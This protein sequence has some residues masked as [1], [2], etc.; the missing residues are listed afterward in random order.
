MIFPEEIWKYIL[1]HLDKDNL[2]RCLL[3]SNEFRELIIKT[4]ELMRKLPVIFFNESWKTKLSFIEQYGVF[5]RSIKFDDCGFK[6]IKDVRNILIQTPNVETLIFYNCYIL[7]AQEIH[8]EERG[9]NAILGN[10][11]GFD[12]F[13]VNNENNNNEEENH[14][15]VS[16]EIDS[17]RN[18]S[19][20]EEEDPLDLLK[21]T[22]LHLDSCN[23][24][25]KVVQNLRTCTT[26]KTFKITFY[27]QSPVNYF[28]NFICQ[29]DSLEELHCVGWSDMV[30]KSLFKNNISSDRIKFKLKK[31]C[32]ECELGYHENFS[33]F[34]RSQAGN[35]KELDLT[36]YNINF[37]YYRLIFNSFKNLTSLTLPTDWFLTDDRV[38]DIK[39]CKIPSLKELELIGAND[40]VASFKTVVEIFPNIE[41]LRA[42]NLMYFSL[43]DILENFSNL[44]HLKAENFR[45]ETMLFVNLPSLKIVEISYLFPMAMSFLWEN[46]AQSCPNIEKLIIKDIGHFK[47]NASIKKEIGLIIKN[48]VNFKELKYC[49]IICSLQ[50]PMVN[51]DED[52]Q[53]AHQFYEHPFYK[54]IIENFSDD[55]KVIKVSQYFAQHCLEYVNVL[56]DIF[57]NCDI[58]E[59]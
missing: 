53:D 38:N 35:L 43:K 54:I 26:L 21:L 34:L 6:S 23:I 47:L 27:Y 29:Q 44:R 57:A 39:D 41:V 9:F 33:K 14:H 42:E 7:E 48:L 59:V 36:C 16:N 20:S 2:K 15:E 49:E 5:V 11:Y 18:S 28:T 32:L 13:V 40:D 46:F 22:F 37:H 12:G 58:I 10:A 50:E 31:F 55:E 19:D 25:K 8:N 56:K 52:Q 17:A 51:A 24:A 3:V 4:P 45:I 30:F 1:C